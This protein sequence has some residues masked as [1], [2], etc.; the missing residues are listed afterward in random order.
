MALFQQFFS[1]KA[2]L[3]F[4]LLVCLTFPDL[5]SAQAPEIKSVYVGSREIGLPI[6]TDF[7]DA[8][9]LPDVVTE[10]AEAITPPTNRLLAALLNRSEMDEVL[11]GQRT[12]FGRYFLVQT[13]RETEYQT[14][15]QEEFVRYTGQNEEEIQRIFRELNPKLLEYLESAEGDIS[16]LLGEEVSLEMNQ[17]VPL[18]VFARS[19]NHFGLTI[20]QMIK[21]DFSE[22][23]QE[24]P[25]VYATNM[26]YFD[27][28][29]LYIYIYSSLASS[30][31]IEWVQDR[32]ERF[33]SDMLRINGVP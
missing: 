32:S 16:E 29:I 3:L 31:D 8:E 17:I 22:N 23:S 26:V 30:Q 7:I 33:V 20:M 9:E 19:R 2:A 18:D 13:L 10:F 25:I 28:K 1:T 27:G 21:A 6:P 15:P 4:G 14:I 5:A 11:E 12:A 24:R